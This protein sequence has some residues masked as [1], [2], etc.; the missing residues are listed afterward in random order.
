MLISNIYS[1]LACQTSTFLRI[2]YLAAV[3]DNM[4]ELIDNSI[5]F[6][7]SLSKLR[8]SGRRLN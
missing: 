1:V 8:G 5:K 6:A 4:Y 2:A 7:L 3:A